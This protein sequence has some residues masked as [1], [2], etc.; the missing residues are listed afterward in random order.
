MSGF[1]IRFIRLLND[2]STDL[3]VGGFLNDAGILNDSQIYDL[4]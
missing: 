3:F 4:T 1:Q 2:D